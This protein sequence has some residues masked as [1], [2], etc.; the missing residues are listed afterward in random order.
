[1]ASSKPSKVPLSQRT[2]RPPPTA[3]TKIPPV[4]IYILAMGLTG[5][6]KSTFISV[7][8]GDSTIRVGDPGE[9]DSVTDSV[10]D[11]V[12]SIKKDGTSY[13]IHLIDSPSFDDGTVADV[14][15]LTRVADFVN[16]HY[17]LGNTLAGVLYL[18]DI[19]K[20]KMGGVGQRNLRMLE[21]MVGID[22]WDN[23]T[24][25]TT[26]WG[27]TTDFA[28][29]EA[30]EKNLMDKDQYF[31]SMLKSGHQA[32]MS[33]GDHQATSQEHLRRRFNPHIS[34]QMAD[35]NGPMLSLGDTDAGR[36]VADGLEE[37]ERVVGENEELVE[38]RQLLT[39]KF[40]EMLFEKYK[41]ERD[42]LIR[43]QR[44]HKAGRWAVRTVIVGGAIVATVVTFGPGASAFALEPAYETYAN[45]Q[46]NDD[47]GKMFS[48]TQRCKKDSETH[49]DDNGGYDPAWLYDRKVKSMN[50]LSDNYNLRS[51][52]STDLSN[53]A[54]V[55]E[56][57]TDLGTITIKDDNIV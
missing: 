45:K 2:L 42:K 43:E 39:R 24:L 6:G 46:R 11:Y 12:L 34:Q 54:T 47:R 19:T 9:L 52:S 49:I 29:E 40:N 36:V 35:P 56:V 37:L 10:A 20:A 17:K 23:C 22:K 38:S 14:K 53:I 28:G 31:G 51:S 7:V 55:G 4:E 41:S 15:V 8:T 3:Q 50:D 33:F 27:C 26:K 57:A 16:T 13:Q 21:Q 44:L 32:S 1:M 30:R 18:H 5:A 48:L 25:V